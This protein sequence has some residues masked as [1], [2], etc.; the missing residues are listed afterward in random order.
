MSVGIPL[1]PILSW[2]FFPL[3]LVCNFECVSSSYSFYSLYFGCILRCLHF[4]FWRG[5]TDGVWGGARVASRYATAVAAVAGDAVAGE[6]ACRI[7][8]ACINC[9]FFLEQ[10]GGLRGGL[11][12]LAR[13]LGFREC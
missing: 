8:W 4:F 5:K 7:L 12:G 9:F 10:E 11:L 1:A 3:L 6:Y 13:Q 2:L